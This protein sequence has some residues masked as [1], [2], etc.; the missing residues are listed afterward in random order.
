M[1]QDLIFDLLTR[2]DYC[3]YLLIYLIPL[4][5]TA[6]TVDQSIYHIRH[7]KQIWQTKHTNA[8]IKPRSLV[9]SGIDRRLVN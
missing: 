6:R 9:K 3:S 5:F 8:S 2:R 1:S 7:L 4:T